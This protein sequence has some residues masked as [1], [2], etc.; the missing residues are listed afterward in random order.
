MS[1]ELAEHEFLKSVPQNTA[2]VKVSIM[3]RV[4]AMRKGEKTEP[5]VRTTTIKCLSRTLLSDRR[6]TMQYV[7]GKSTVQGNAKL[8]TYKLRK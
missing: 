7:N 6:S 4:L 5:K 3:H 2:N 8:I 1:F